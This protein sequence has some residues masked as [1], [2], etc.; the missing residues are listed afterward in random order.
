MNATN[1]E[2]VESIRIVRADGNLQISAADGPAEIRASV[3][4]S[5]VRDG[6]VAEV[7]IRSSAEVRV[8]AGVALEVIHCAGNLDA[9]DLAAPLAI[10]RVAGNLRAR[11][12][13]A[14]SVREKV[15]GNATLR[16]VAAVDG[17]RVSGT[18]SVEEAR[19]VSFASVAG[20]LRA[21]A[22]DGDLAVEHV[23]G[24]ATV[25][26]VGGAIRSR[27]V[28]GRLY[29]ESVGEVEVET[30]GGKAR[31]SSV[32][33]SVRAARVGGRLTVDDVGGDLIVERVGGH[34]MLARVAGA[35]ALAEIGGAA[36][37][38]GPYAAGK[39]WSVHSRGRA[40]LELDADS[41]L[42]L[43]ASSGSGRV[44]LFGIDGAG[45]R[46]SGGNRV[47][48]EIGAP[49][50]GAEPTRVAI[51]AGRG[52]VIVARPGAREREYCG[53]GFRQERPSPGA[54]SELGDI[55]AEE[56]GREVPRFVGAIL[57]AA[58]QFASRT[59]A[60]SGGLV[61]DVTDDVA[62]SVRE[63][64]LEMQRTLDDVEAKVPQE[65]AARLAELGKRIEEL[66]RSASEDGRMRSREARREMREKIRD[67][68]R[69][70][71]EAIRQAARESRERAGESRQG[72]ATAAGQSA[73][74]GV[75]P[76][77]TRPLN[78]EAAAG[79]MMSILRA[80]RE[81]KLEPEEADEMIAALM[82]VERAAEG[83]R[84]EPR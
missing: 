76:G 81:G 60:W 38:R 77:V 62:R 66:V 23:G 37:L 50:E 33:R 45:L 24:G 14:M 41:A 39:S 47:E 26:R 10:G 54:F 65:V 58:G 82:E 30:I 7:T 42:A 11:R 80:V 69:E 18:L 48:G 63:A 17:E 5:I 84:S 83:G 9:E 57:G 59:G 34:A 28:G 1:L 4:P 56:F 15:S 53:R 29:A 31:A 40:V 27:H 22:I 43:I 78:P 75:S 49:H 32:A 46:W 35:V 20:E 72:A 55:I 13:G 6:G 3:E 73:D 19:S 44:R 74:A 2:G 12:I 25:E 36:Y 64:M 16:Q 51:E 68:A 70:M 61:R 21:R 79:D 52:D 67:A 71:R 8:P